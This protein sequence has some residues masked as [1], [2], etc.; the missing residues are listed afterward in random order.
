[1]SDI[2]LSVG[3]QKGA[4]ETK[5]LQ[6]DLQSIISQLDQNPPK[7]KVGLQV[8]QSA[9]NH[10]KSQLTQ[11]VNSVGLSKGAP[12][13]V[14]ISGLGE[15]TTHANNA[16]DALGNMAKA[17]KVAQDATSNA[18]NA[19]TKS[20]S[21]AKKAAIEL[22]KAEAE[23]QRLLRKATSLLTQMQDAE[24]N[25]TKA[26]KGSTKEQYASVQSYISQ[27]QTLRDQFESGAID[28]ATF[29]ARLDSLST[30]FSKAR[31]EIKGAGEATKT[32]S[33]HFGSLVEK[34]GSWLTV[35]QVVMAAIRSIKQMVNNVIKLD[36][37][38]TELKKV[39]DESDATY[40]RFLVN[41]TSRAKGLGAALTDVV[42]ATADFARLGYG[43]EDASKLADAALIYKNVG[44]G[45]EDIN[46]ASESIVSTM[47]AFQ[48]NP[49]NVMHVVDVFNSIGNSFAI[50]SGGIGEA[51]QRSS[52]AM[53][54]AGN[55]LEETAALIA[56]GNTVLQNPN[57]MGTTL[58]TVSMFLRASKVEAEEAGESTEGMANS[59][60]ELRDSL[61]RL[62]GSRVDIL[63]DSGQYKSTYEIL[64]DIAAV[65]DDIVANQGTDSAAILELL[66]GRS[67][68]QCTV[69][70]IKV[71]I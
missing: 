60:S 61:L 3:L 69:M 50:S 49:S 14:N 13:T 51:L 59:V 62:T 10:F 47:Q 34:F 22:A 8:D 36:T 27:I 41:A 32:L 38:M 39:T 63:T 55:T 46:Q 66:G 44:D 48:I 5:Q 21:D 7:V 67:L 43:I 42:S 45:I 25:W 35:S 54:A 71:R 37:A 64:R 58:K 15:V 31:S 19:T 29:K 24:R 23:R 2:L 57:V 4:A 6:T 20:T 70:C 68:P 26:A 56:A 28:T 40:D 11:I 12:I 9:I 1:M 33:G 16:K 30:G 18:A 52:A 17:A 53:Y 65:W